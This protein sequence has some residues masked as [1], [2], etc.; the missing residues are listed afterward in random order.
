MRIKRNNSA[1]GLML[2]Q[3]SCQYLNSYSLHSISILV[4]VESF[5]KKHI[6]VLYVI[7]LL[8]NPNFF[9][10]ILYMLWISV[11]ATVMFNQLI[12]INLSVQGEEGCYLRTK[13]MNRGQRID[14]TYSIRCLVNKLLDKPAYQ[15][16]LKYYFFVVVP[17]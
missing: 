1:H 2:K 5:L 8:T 4:T 13:A 15:I 14:R 6:Y 9:N 12:Y 11:Y 10:N 7:Y 3:T 17:S 16:N